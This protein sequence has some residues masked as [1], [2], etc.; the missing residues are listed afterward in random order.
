MLLSKMAMQRDKWFS[1]T[2][3]SRQVNYRKPHDDLESLVT[4]LVNSEIHHG[5]GCKLR[6]VEGFERPLPALLAVRLA[7]DD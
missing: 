5:Y 4:T 3:A 7:D 1:L 6:K 2:L